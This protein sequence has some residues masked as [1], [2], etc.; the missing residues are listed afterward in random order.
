MPR[1]K[2]YDDLLSSLVSALETMPVKLAC[3]LVGICPTTYRRWVQWGESG[4]EPYASFLSLANES[5]A[6]YVRGRL[7]V[8]EAAAA[9]DWK[10]AAWYLERA[11]PE[12]YAKTTNEK[13]EISGPGGAPLFGSQPDPQAVNDALFI[14]INHCGAP[15]APGSPS[16]SGADQPSDGSDRGD[17]HAGP[18]SADPVLPA[19]PN[20]PPG[21]VPADG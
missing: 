3:D 5:R 19:Q 7:K 15:P 16:G 20:G 21:G 17:G 12:H 10:A 2:L 11:F 9:K 14:L 8:I 13:Q 1:A 18:G 4:E 6:A